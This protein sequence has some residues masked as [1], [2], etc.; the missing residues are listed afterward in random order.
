VSDDL[1]HVP[2]APD[3]VE[4]V[5]NLRGAVLPVIDQRKRL[6][7]PPVER[8]DR[9]RIMVFLI[10]GFRTGFIVDAVTEV[11]KIPKSAI[12]S[13]PKLSGAQARLLGR[14]ANLEKQKRMIQLIDPDFLVDDSDQASLAAMGA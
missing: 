2:K 3:F 10:K 14:V 6:D 7:L 1:T 12:E 4:G 11:L 5:I 13:S 9:Q 8:N